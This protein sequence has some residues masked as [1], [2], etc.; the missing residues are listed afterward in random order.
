MGD[1]KA[2][3][4]DIGRVLVSF[5]NRQE[6]LC[7]IA[8]RFSSDGT[9]DTSCFSGL[10]GRSLLGYL[11]TGQISHRALWKITCE[12]ARIH[13]RK[14][15]WHRFTV[16]YVEHLKPV[17]PVLEVIRR[18]QES[19]ITVAVSNGDFGSTYAIDMLE[20]HYGIRFKKRFESWQV[21]VKK[22][23]LYKYVLN[24]LESEHAIN[25]DEVVCVDDI[26]EY[27]TVANRIGMR[28]IVFNATTEPV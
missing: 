18:V 16:L 8:K 25:A 19:Y 20:T 12:A 9:P 6:V 26:I 14:L 10:F 2:V 17:L 21:G 11:D 13:P 1:V 27:I 5:E 22:P 24:F 7:R 3:L 28:G 15:P 23:C 4:W